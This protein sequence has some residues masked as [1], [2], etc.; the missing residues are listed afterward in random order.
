MRR[1]RAGILRS[2]TPSG[3]VQER[4]G[5]PAHEPLGGLGLPFEYVQSGGEA[6]YV[7]CRHVF[8]QGHAVGRLDVKSLVVGRGFVHAC[9]AGVFQ[10]HVVDGRHA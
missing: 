8:L 3:I 7:R 5:L 10:N 6:V 9:R 4:I 2:G 1:G